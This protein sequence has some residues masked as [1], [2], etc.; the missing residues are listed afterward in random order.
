M[1][2]TDFIYKHEITVIKSNIIND[3]V[4]IIITSSSSSSSC[5]LDYTDKP[6]C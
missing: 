3:K 5:S 1:I 6:D 4:N 2:I